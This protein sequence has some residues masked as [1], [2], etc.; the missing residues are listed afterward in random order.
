MTL[1]ELFGLE[2]DDDDG[3]FDFFDFKPKKSKT[4]RSNERCHANPLPAQNR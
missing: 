1:L 2:F 4:R 3:E